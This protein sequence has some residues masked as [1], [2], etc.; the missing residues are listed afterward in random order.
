MSMLSG[1]RITRAI[2]FVV[3]SRCSIGNVSPSA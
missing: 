3:A 2:S 1:T